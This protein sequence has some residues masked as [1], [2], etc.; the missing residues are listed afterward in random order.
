[1]RPAMCATSSAAPFIQTMQHL[2]LKL[3]NNKLYN[4]Q[5]VLSVLRACSTIACALCG[6]ACVGV[7]HAMDEDIKEP[8]ASSVIEDG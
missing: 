2:Y 8:S 7:P 5:P 4:E 6:A 1:M 3:G